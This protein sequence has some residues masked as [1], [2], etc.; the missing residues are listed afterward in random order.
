LIFLGAV[1][2]GPTSWARSRRE[3]DSGSDVTLRVYNYA[4]VEPAT[5]LLAEN[6]ATRILAQAGVVASWVD[7]PTSHSEWDRYPLCQSAW[8]ANDLAVRFLPETMANF[9]T[10]T[11]DW[12]GFAL[13]CA[14]PSCAASVIYDRVRSLAGG[15]TAPTPILLG[16]VVAHE[17]GHLLLGADSHSRTGIM[18]AGWS[19]RELSWEASHELV[20]TRDQ[21]RRMNDRL[22]ER[23]QVEQAEPKVLGIVR[24]NW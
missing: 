8:Q 23:L 11:K 22:A 2:I 15:A 3:A 20:F 24:T 5:V 4:Q 1:I 12:L 19:D 18:S 21:A 13:D 9:P 17:I 7:C 14:A 16:R 10:N 6:E